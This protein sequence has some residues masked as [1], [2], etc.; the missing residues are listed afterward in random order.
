MN[1][2][3]FKSLKD[4]SINIRPLNIFTGLNGMGKSSFIQTLLL[5]LKCPFHHLAS[6]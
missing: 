4:V 5:L 2:K 6:R 1:I 3:N